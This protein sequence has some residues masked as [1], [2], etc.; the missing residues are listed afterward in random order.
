MSRAIVKM[1]MILLMISLAV[2]AQEQQEESADSWKDVP[3]EDIEKMDAVD[4]A[5]N[6]GKL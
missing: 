5:D 1:A 6:W 4:L 2:H 3:L